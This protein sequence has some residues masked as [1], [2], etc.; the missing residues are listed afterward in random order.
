MRSL[1][2]FLVSASCG[3]LGGP[4]GLAG[5]PVLQ[6]S[7][8]GD[9]LVLRWNEA[10]FELQ[11]CDQLG[12]G[13]SAA[14]GEP[15]L[16]GGLYELRYPMLETTRFYRLRGSG[17]PFQTPERMGIILDASGQPLPGAEIDDGLW[18]DA[19]GVWSGTPT[20]SGAG[21]YRAS[22][23]GFAATWCQPVEF[24][25]SAV[26]SETRLTPFTAVAR[27]AGGDSAQ[28]HT[29]P[30][31]SPQVEVTVAADALAVLPAY[32]G[33]AEPDL[34]DVDA[35]FAPLD[36]LDGGTLIR[37]I[38]LQVVDEAGETVTLAANEEL[39]LKVHDFDPEAAVPVLG[40]F[41]PDAGR[42]ESVEDAVTRAGDGSLECRLNE[43]APL[44]GLFAEGLGVASSA[45]G[46]VRPLAEGYSDQAY[47]AARARL[48]RRLKELAD[49][50]ATGEDVDVSADPEV[51]SALEEMARL[52]RDFGAANPSEAGKVKLMTVAEAAMLLG[53]DALA[54]DLMQEAREIAEELA[55]KLLGEGDCGRVREMLHAMEQLMLMGG[56]EALI[57]A[58]QEKLERL[59][60]ECD[61]WTGSIT[62]LFFIHRVHP[63]VDDLV[64]SSGGGTWSERH[65]VRIA[66]HAKTHVVTGEDR[67]NLRFPEVQYQDPEAD[68][69][70]SIAFYGQPQGHVLWLNFGGTYDGHEFNLTDVGPAGG[71]A[72]VS[73]TQRWVFKQEIEDVGCVD[74]PGFPQEFAFPNYYSALMHGF[75]ESPPITLQEMLETDTH[76]GQGEGE[77]IRG[78][79]GVED[80]QPDLG[81]YPF[82]SGH[83][84]WNFIHVQAIL[85]LEE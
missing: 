5:G 59:F 12:N 15:S 17:I 1:L 44:Y 55:R 50:M 80:P 66:T 63:G 36:A 74:L 71:T 54:D 26:F 47:K 14:P 7:K 60:K 76:S 43:L 40:Q 46:Q 33:L 30:A 73:I 57:Q 16:K 79:E 18:A 75:L 25:E 38:A 2:S 21:W 13:W 11:Q 32:V 6:H 84:V 58:L 9:S 4:A 77:T 35:S 19:D 64:L 69:E 49:M 8:A 29:G 85:P 3:V 41:D 68:C 24:L 62:Y 42:W 10:G 23:F 83:V 20:P 81:K 65:D 48:V 82:T 53:H 61:V 39:I 22:A 56:D 67:A 28:L 72:P 45:P 70:I 78:S 51:Q 34:L 37:V 31:N 52:A 27:L